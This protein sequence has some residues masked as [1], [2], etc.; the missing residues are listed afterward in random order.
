M[1]YTC[2]DILNLQVPWSGKSHSFIRRAC[3][4]HHISDRR[5]LP[6]GTSMHFS[7]FLRPLGVIGHELSVRLTL[8]ADLNFLP[9]GTFISRCDI[10]RRRT[11]VA[12]QGCQRM[13]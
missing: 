2:N 13:A 4:N 6:P 12:V 7:Q 9:A 10:L 8:V 3:T 1:L 5:V 11:H